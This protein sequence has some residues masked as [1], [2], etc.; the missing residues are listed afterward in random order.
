ME[1]VDKMPEVGL[2]RYRSTHQEKLTHAVITDV[3]WLYL[4]QA[5]YDRMVFDYINTGV[6]GLA[7][8]MDD[9]YALVGEELELTSE[10]ERE[11]YEAGI[12]EGEFIAIA[13]NRMEEWNGTAFRLDS[14]GNLETPLK[15]TKVFSCGICKV[16]ADFTEAAKLGP[17]MYLSILKEDSHILWHVCRDCANG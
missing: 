1:D 14:L 15:T 8:F 13:K 17:G 5:E 4:E 16:H 11:A 12:S 2:Y 10:Q 3:D 6:Y 7:G 9:D